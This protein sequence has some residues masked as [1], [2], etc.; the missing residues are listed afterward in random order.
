MSRS[1]QFVGLTKEAQELV[2]P[3][4]KIELYPMTEGMF[5]ETIM[6]TVYYLKDKDAPKDCYWKFTEVVQALPSSGGLVILTNLHFE[7]F[8]E[9]GERS[10]I[11]CGLVCSWRRDPSVE[12][13]IEP[14]TGRYW[15]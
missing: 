4:Y 11:D 13:E 2:S 12:K 7:I 5:N 9:T 3:A 14:E 6:G 10:P 1:T 15:I 8:F